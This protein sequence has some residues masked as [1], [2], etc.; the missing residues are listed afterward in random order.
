MPASEL[1]TGR[2]DGEKMRILLNV[3]NIYFELI[4]ISD[5][6][7]KAVFAKTGLLDTACT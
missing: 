3:C 4:G 6:N 2:H 5:E 7:T 1:Y